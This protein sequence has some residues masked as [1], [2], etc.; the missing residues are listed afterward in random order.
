VLGLLALRFPV[1]PLT[2]VL[3]VLSMV[4]LAN[5]GRTPADLSKLAL[6]AALTGFC[7]NGAIVGM[8]SIF[9]QAYPTAVRAFGTGFAIGIGR[10]GSALA[11]VLGGYLRAAGYSWPTVFAIMSGSALIAAILL[12]FLKLQPGETHG[13][14][15][16]SQS[17]APSLTG[18]S[19]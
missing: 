6:F 9:A 12:T 3:M 5:F 13:E 19:T 11:P 2:I 1:K 17:G 10:G 16:E 8:Y 18:A 7:T 15:Q 4:T 14:K